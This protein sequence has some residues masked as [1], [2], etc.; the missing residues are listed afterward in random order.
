MGWGW[1]CAP[2]GWT[3]LGWGVF[4]GVGRRHWQ[5][6]LSKTSMGFCGM[7]VW[8][9][10]APGVSKICLWGHQRAKGLEG[11]T[12]LRHLSP[13]QW[14]L[15]LGPVSCSGFRASFQSAP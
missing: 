7:L 14:T 8:A 3:H 5:E 2:P 4:V 9:G 6:P 12:C 15:T 11:V 1:I 10:M 13:G